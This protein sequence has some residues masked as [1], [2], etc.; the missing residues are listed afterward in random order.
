MRSLKTGL[1]AIAI[2][3]VVF[4]AAMGGCSADGGSTVVTEPE[5]TDP[6]SS[7]AVLPPE[8]EKP[9][10]KVD[11]GT[12]SGKKAD[13]GKT[14]SGPP[15]AGP[16]PPVAGTAC[17]K[18]DEIKTKACGA[19]G[20]AS[21]VCLD[22][23]T[24]KLKW[25][26]YSACENELVGGCIPGTVVNEPCGNCGTMKKTCTAYCAYTSGACTGQPAVNCKPG[27]VEYITAGCPTS[28]TYRNRTCGAACTWGGT[29]ATCEEPNNPNKMTAA[30]TVGGVVSATWTLAPGNVMKRPY[31]CGGSS[32][33]SPDLQYVAVEIKNPNPTSIEVQL[34]HSA[35]PGGDELDTLIWVYSKILPPSTDAEIA[36]CMPS[37]IG[38]Q[39][40]CTG[41]TPSNKCGNADSFNFAG[42]KGVPIPA[43]GK[44]LVYSSGYTSGETGAFNLNVETTK[45]N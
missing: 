42:V 10:N 36:A 13:S 21:T 27:T 24:G 43:N 41:T 1:F 11:S 45:V 33:S 35:A 2:S 9:D 8:G 22:D 38:I 31:S 34:Y 14:D 6:G 16:P 4:A 12:D 3:G 28:G 29:S 26:E 39:D 40:S 44:I 23:G 30:A 18:A 5:P 7:G 17:T 19:C 15:D 20:K 32:F 37:P 25:S